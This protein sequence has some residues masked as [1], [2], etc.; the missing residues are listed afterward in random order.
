M[1][2]TGYRAGPKWKN[3]SLYPCL[4]RAEDSSGYGGEA[5]SSVDFTCTLPSY[6]MT[7]PHP[8]SSDLPVNSNGSIILH[9]YLYRS[10][11][12]PVR[13]SCSDYLTPES[14]YLL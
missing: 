9:H 3:Y 11:E 7:V 13:L 5:T 2:Q 10:I 1:L 12:E 4:I 14:S 6:T 8:H